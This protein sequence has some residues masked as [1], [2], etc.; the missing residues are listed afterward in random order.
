M[1]YTIN[2]LIVLLFCVPV[3]LAVYYRYE[4]NNVLK[5]IQAKK[6]LYSPKVSVIIPFKGEDYN[7]RNTV[8]SLLTQKYR[9][10]YELLFVTSDCQSKSIDIIK[11]L[12]EKKKNAFLI[13]ARQDVN[14]G[15][16]DKIN[17]LLTGVENASADTEVYLF[18]DSDMVAHEKWIENMVQ[19]L[20]FTDCG[21]VSGSAWVVSKQ[22][23][24]YEL[25]TRFWDF[26]ATTMITFPF[27][28]FARGLS[29]GIRKDNYKKLQIEK[30]WNKAFHDNFTLSDA[31]RK[32][33]MRIYYAPN[34]IIA[35]HFNVETG[36]AWVSWIKRQAVHTKLHFKKLWA[37]G[38]FLVTFPRF[39]GAVLSVLTIGVSLVGARFYPYLL[40][41]YL[42]PIIQLFSALVTVHM[43]YQDATAMKDVQNSFKGKF[44]LALA[45]FITVWHCIG[46]FWALFSTKIQWRQVIYKD[47]VVVG[48][49]STND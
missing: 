17:N 36:F 43:V 6:E 30:V 45:S 9:G 26:L 48:G 14:S 46:S 31:V 11:E 34:C 10:D 47:N 32:A 49:K 37:F 15:R 5:K 33:N 27:T 18:I 39:F 3:F 29:N 7:F 38:F 24:V 23:G 12:T 8:E 35:E 42:W 2:L 22:G 40:A 25:A 4:R 16:G 44:R 21:I 28:S 1:W 13:H 41:F 20:Q 19:P